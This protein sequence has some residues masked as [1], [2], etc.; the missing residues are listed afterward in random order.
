MDLYIR[1]TY[2][3][4]VTRNTDEYGAQTYL[5]LDFSPIR[6]SLFGHESRKTGDTD[7]L[8]EYRL[9]AA[10]KVCETCPLLLSRRQSLPNSLQ[11]NTGS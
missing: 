9:Q 11:W 5:A 3:S 10:W 7:A 2:H 8:A 6:L 4:I 1:R